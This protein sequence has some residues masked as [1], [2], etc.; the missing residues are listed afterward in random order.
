M[1]QKE[2]NWNPSLMM[3]GIAV[4][5]KMEAYI[6]NLFRRHANHSSRV[7]CNV[8][9]NYTWRSVMLGNIAGGLKAFLTAVMP[10]LGAKYVKHEQDMP[11]PARPN[12]DLSQ[13]HNHF[14]FHAKVSK[15]VQLLFS[16]AKIKSN[17]L[18][19]PKHSLKSTYHQ[20]LDLH[21]IF[22]F[23]WFR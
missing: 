16:S 1:R 10:M 6:K 12:R 3:N 15:T 17:V 22:F 20:Y 13:L 7:F 23:T 21:S 18:S 9:C 11:Q 2:W 19:V 8:G 5:L 14:Y 4:L